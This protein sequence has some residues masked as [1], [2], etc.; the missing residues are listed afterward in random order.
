LRQA[1]WLSKPYAPSASQVC[2]GSVAI[3]TADVVR[4]TR[5]ACAGDHIV[6]STRADFAIGLAWLTAL[7]YLDGPL[8]L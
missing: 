4:S 8:C 5:G 2:A 1:P 7:V 6:S 3:Q